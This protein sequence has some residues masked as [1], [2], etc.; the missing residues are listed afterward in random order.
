[1]Y[2]PPY[3]R[4]ATDY[5]HALQVEAATGDPLAR[6][7]SAARA[8]MFIESLAFE[9]EAAHTAALAVYLPAL[10]RMRVAQIA[11]GHHHH[12]APLDVEAMASDMLEQV[13]GSAPDNN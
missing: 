7:L 10:A 11:T 8:E 3:H 6:K 2:Q 13:F 1:M 5:R 4:A 12:H 9:M